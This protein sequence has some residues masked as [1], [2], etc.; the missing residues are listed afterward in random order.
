VSRVLCVSCRV[1]W[2]VRTRFGVEFF[3][4]GEVFDVGGVGKQ[5]RRVG[6]RD[7]E[8]EQLEV[9]GVTLPRRQL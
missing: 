5:T 8:D 4:G 2:R 1:V 6:L 7:D 3:G 9:D